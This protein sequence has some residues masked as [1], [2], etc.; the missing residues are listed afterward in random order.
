MS[1]FNAEAIFF[2][3]GPFLAAFSLF[4]SFQ[5]A[6]AQST[7]NIL[8]VDADVVLTKEVHFEGHGYGLT[9]QRFRTLEFSKCRFS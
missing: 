2:E 1:N 8:F 7:F 3:N 5:G 6:E 4:S 9:V